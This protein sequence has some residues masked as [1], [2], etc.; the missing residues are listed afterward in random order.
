M[1]YEFPNRI[2][3]IDKQTYQP[4]YMK[5][6]DH[7]IYFA[8]DETIDDADFG[9]WLIGLF[10]HG[11]IAPIQTWA[12]TKD[13]ISGIDYRFYT[14]I[15]I[16]ASIGEKDCYQLVVYNSVTSAIKYVPFNGIN[17]IEQQNV[18]N[19]AYLQWRN[20]TN[21]DNYNYETLSEYNSVFLDMNLIDQ[22]FEYTNKGYREQSTGKFRLQKNQRHKA[23]T[24]ETYLFDEQANDTMGSISLHDDILIN[25]EAVTVKTGHEQTSQRDLNIN[26][27]S[28]VFYVDKYSTINVK[29]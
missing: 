27:G 8:L 23:Y 7:F 14:T 16:D 20:S 26:K 17:I 6:L 15:N 29:T 28:I 11:D 5:E 12:L 1:I 9:D 24:F 22:D 18:T 13:I 25:G 19:Y 2:Q 3:Q 10:R 21:L 4:T